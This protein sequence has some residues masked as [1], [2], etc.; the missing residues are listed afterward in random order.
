GV[1]QVRVTL[2]DSESGETVVIEQSPDGRV[3][4]E[5]AKAR[6][7]ERAAN[8]PPAAAEAKTAREPETKADKAKP[9]RKRAAKEAGE[10]GPPKPRASRKP[11]PAPE[12]APTPTPGTALEWSPVKDHEYDGFAAPSAAGQ[13]KVLISK[14]SQWALFYELKGTWPKH[15]ACFAK[16]DNAKL[17]AQELHDAGWPESEFGPITAG[18]VARACP[19]PTRAKSKGTDKGKDEEE[20]MKKPKAE[21]K[22]T[23][24]PPSAEPPQMPQD[25]ELLTSFASD[26][27]AVLDEDEDD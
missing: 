9:A 6:R 13:F 18:Q 17:R 10:T 3:K 4:C 2:E 23:A 26:L 24:A 19:A 16:L 15:I 25:K 22:P 12:P 14:N 20:T 7:G 11:E 21:E 27:D 1:Q 8:T 5:G